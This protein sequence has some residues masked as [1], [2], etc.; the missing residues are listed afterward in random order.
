MKIKK[1]NI[2]NVRGI[3]SQEIIA[4]IYPNKPTFFVA[5]NGFGKSSIA[6]AFNSINRNKIDVIE[7]NKY[8]ND[9]E[10]NSII[11]LYDEEGSYMADRTSNTISS[12]YSVF[13]ISSQVKP[14]AATRNFGGYASSVP[15]LVVEPIILYDKIPN[16]KDF[17]YSLSSMKLNFGSSAGKILV[18]LKNVLSCPNIVSKISKLK[19]EFDKLLQTRNNDKISNFIKTINQINGTATQIANADIDLTQ[20]ISI[21][22][23]NKISNELDFLFEDKTT[24]EKAINI[25]QL[26][27]IYK[28]NRNHLSYIFSYYNFLNDKCEINEMLSFFNCTWKNIRACKKGN[29]FILEFPK[30]TQI[31]NGERDIL[32]FIGKLFE[33]KSKLRKAKNILIIDEIFDYLDDA[34]LIAS[35]YFITKFIKQFKDSGKE[36]FPII[37][38]HLDPMFFNTYSFSTKNV[39]YLEKTSQISN[40]YKINNML[41]DRDKCKKQN[42]SIYDIISS[43]YLHFSNDNTT[44]AIEYLTGIDVDNNINT[45]EQFKSKAFE[46]LYLYTSGYNYDP[47]LVCCGLR[48]KIEEM[49][50]NQLPADFQNTF[51]SMFKTLERISYAKEK[52][53]TV[54][55][56]H[57]LLSIIYN[58]AMHLDSQ[59][60]KLNPIAYKLKN[61][62]IK[63]MISEL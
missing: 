5:P 24:N 6:T 33:A 13:V 43:K 41:K 4:D 26:K 51:L 14:K 8:K 31:S 19:S 53:A 46:E 37:L 63:H 17:A 47:A 3:S 21:E 16:K 18:N 20:L 59:C 54:P 28:E 61:K 23:F 12:K 29:K 30:A 55:E 42:K 57:F 40:K 58:E 52:G 22:S 49:A 10:L 56:V 7:E 9:K 62:V 25:I 38:T 1:I 11:E 2:E 39:I 60:Q 48:L 32:C 50:F 15:S 44:A 27:E 36:L 35:Q 34:N 45:P